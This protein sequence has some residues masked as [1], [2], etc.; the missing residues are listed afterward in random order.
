MKHLV[1]ASLIASSLVFVQPASADPDKVH[2]VLDWVVYGRSTPYFVALEKG[3]FK[4]NNIDVTI[5]RGYGSV[6]SLKRIAA[7]QADFVLADFGGLILARANEKLPAKMITIIYAKNGHA[8][9]YLEGSGIKSPADLAG[10][11]V[12]AAPG[13]TTAALFPAF[14]RANNTDPSKTQVVSVDPQAL[15]A[16][17]LAKQFDAML[18]FNFNNALLVKEGSK[19]GLKPKVM[20]YADNNF[21]FYANGIITTDAMIQKN[22]DLVRRF[23]AAIVEGVKYTFD[24]PDESCQLLRKHAPSVD[25]DVCLTEVGLVKDLAISDEQKTNG[26]GYMSKAGVQHTI[27][28]LKEHMGLK[29][30]IT[31]E[32]TFDMQ[33]LPKA[34]G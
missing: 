8:V 9:H 4:K 20:M 2:F 15:N 11:R 26:I 19:S 30:P 23:S 29:N 10:K 1:T 33:F 21:M 12:A 17:L 32:E 3:F 34:G 5:E 24:H 28:I 31:P 7:G 27:D 25:Q 18:E 6:A 22:P 14:L 13:T 16:V